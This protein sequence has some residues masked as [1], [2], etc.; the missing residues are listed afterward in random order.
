MGN[1]S[2][3]A[4]NKRRLAA[5]KAAQASSQSHQLVNRAGVAPP[6]DNSAQS[7]SA[8][9]GS[10]H[11]QEGSDLYAAL[12]AHGGHGGHGGY[13]GGYGHSSYGY[14]AEEECPEG[15][16]EDLALLLT[17]AALA[18]SG[19]VIFREITLRTRRKKRSDGDDIFSSVA[20]K[21]VAGMCMNVL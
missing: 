15:I 10:D 7:L 9:A 14:L 8:G 5:K 20:G 4:A 2:T 6:A 17:A 19:F 11:Q 13:G 16:D 12:S 18:A 3:C 21:M 1:V